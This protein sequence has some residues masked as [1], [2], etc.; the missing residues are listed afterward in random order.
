F[1][2]GLLSNHFIGRRAFNNHFVGRIQSVAY[3]TIE[4]ERLA[5]IGDTAQVTLQYEPSTTLKVGTPFY[6]GP[7]PNGF[8]L[9]TLAFTPAPADYSSAAVYTDYQLPPALVISAIRGRELTVKHV[10]A[11]AVLTRFSPQP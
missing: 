10:G 9:S 2:F 6:Y 5:E 11:D 7:N 4:E 3:P 1:L 8:P